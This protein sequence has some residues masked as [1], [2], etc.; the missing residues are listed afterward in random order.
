MKTLTKAEEQIMQV[1]WKIGPSFVKDIIDEMPEPKPHYNTVSTL[2]KILVDKGFASFKA[3]GKSHQYH[4]LVSKEEY[5]HKTVK[6]LVSGYF[7]GSF[8]NMVSFFVK[9]KDMSVADLEQ[10]LQQIKDSK[11]QVK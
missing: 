7:E 8:S 10:L 4:A 9:E 1:L 5:S 6:N 11:N 2:V 3:Y